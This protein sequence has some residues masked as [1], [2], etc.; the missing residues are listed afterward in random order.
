MGPCWWRQNESVCAASVP[1]LYRF[2]SLHMALERS[3]ISDLGLWV[4]TTLLISYFSKSTFGSLY[5]PWVLCYLG[6]VVACLVAEDTRHESNGIMKQVRDILVLP[7]LL[8]TM[9]TIIM[10]Y[11]IFLVHHVRLFTSSSPYEVIVWVLCLVSVSLWSLLLYSYVYIPMLSANFDKDL[12]VRLKKSFLSE[13]K[14]ALTTNRR[15]AD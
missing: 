6:L 8:S 9:C 2:R 7:L 14:K 12:P 10:P 13:I 1:T 4:L 15:H 11:Q 3:F 5:F